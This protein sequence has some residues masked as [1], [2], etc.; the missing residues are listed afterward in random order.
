LKTTADIRSS[1][2]SNTVLFVTEVLNLK[3]VH[4]DKEEEF[5]CFEL[6]SGEILELSGQTN[7]WHP[8]STPS[9]W[10]LVVADVR[11]TKTKE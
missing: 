9:D 2:F 7:I 6:P 5:A 11:H 8:F 10:E 4:H 1:Y 3:M